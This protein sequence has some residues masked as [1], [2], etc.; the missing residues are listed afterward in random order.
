MIANAQK[1]CEPLAGDDRKACMERANGNGTTTGSVAAG[2]ELHEYVQVVPGTP[3][4]P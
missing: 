3:A 4:K 2:G 1:R